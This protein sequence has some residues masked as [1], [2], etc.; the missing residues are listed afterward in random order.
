MRRL[1]NNFF[2]W[3]T[4]SQ[5][6]PPTP[7]PP[8]P[9]P[10]APTDIIT[11]L[12]EA[13]NR[14]RSQRNIPPLFANPRLI[15]AAQKH[16]QW[17]ANNKKMSHTGSGGSSFADR[18]R[19]EGYSLRTGGENVAAG[20]KSVESVIAGWMNSTGHR[21]NI[22]NSNYKEIGVG[23]VND[24]WC[25]VFATPSSNVGMTEPI[26]ELPVGIEADPN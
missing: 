15:A 12:L 3:L 24:Y 2:S 22:L 16:A 20:Y 8:A 5:P 10:T 25:A 7:Q 21:A 14:Q 9:P 13:H 6:K 26:V 18:I 11:Q 19:A 1:L 17:M 4:G 23:V